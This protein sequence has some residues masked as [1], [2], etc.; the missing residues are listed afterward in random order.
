MELIAFELASELLEPN[1]KPILFRALISIV[2]FFPCQPR[3][4]SKVPV[5]NIRQFFACHPGP[6]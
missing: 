5:T 6:N 3:V 4:T 1:L 2:D